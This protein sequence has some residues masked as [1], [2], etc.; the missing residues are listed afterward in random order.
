[1]VW[2]FYEHSASN[3]YAL[4]IAE[5]FLCILNGMNF[6]NKCWIL[7]LGQSNARHKYKLG[8]AWL[9]II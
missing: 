2:I 3:V 4:V 1:M 6:N 7:N 9:E 8:E 5:Q